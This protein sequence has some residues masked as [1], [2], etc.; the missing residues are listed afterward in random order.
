MGDRLEEEMKLMDLQER[1]WRWVD[2]SGG[3][4]ACWN[5]TGSVGREGYGK[6]HLI[7]PFRSVGSH[8]VSW[9]LTNGVIPDG[10]F[11]LHH[12]DNRL[13][14]NPAHLFL[15]TNSDNMQDA[16]M[17]GKKPGVPSEPYRIKLSLEMANEIR[18][19]WI[20]GKWTKRG[21]AKH[22]GICPRHIRNVLNN[23]VW[24]S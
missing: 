23:E 8:R 3:R 14:V 18:T 11:V 22:F 2:R 17:K 19:M 13:C 1:F 9:E 15:G 10:L 20:S 4:N 16:I 24:R 5:W 21:L 12:C 7:K 6:F